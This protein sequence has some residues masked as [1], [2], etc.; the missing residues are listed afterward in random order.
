MG[1]KES[2]EDLRRSDG[3][4]RISGDRSKN[5]RKKISGDRWKMG[6]KESQKIGA[7]KGGTNLRRKVEIGR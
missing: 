1:G 2:Q 5:G 4:S 7:K 3:R 6:S